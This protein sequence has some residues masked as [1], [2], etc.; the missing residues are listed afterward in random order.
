M[1]PAEDRT[2]RPERLGEILGTEEVRQMEGHG[3]IHLISLLIT[4]LS[5]IGW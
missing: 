2:V 3:S 4:W 1:R 5:M